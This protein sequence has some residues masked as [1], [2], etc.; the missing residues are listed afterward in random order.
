MQKSIASFIDHTILSPVAKKEDIISACQQADMWG[1]ASVCIHPY[2]VKLATKELQGS[3]CKVTTVVGF[4][5]GQNCFPTKVFET[6]KALEEGADEID[7]VLN[8]SAL[9]QGLDSF[10]LDELCSIKEASN[11]HIVK[12]IIET[13]YLADHEKKLAC[14]LILRSGADFVKTSTGFAKFGATVDDVLLLRKLVGSKIGVKASG[15][16]GTLEVAESM[17]RAGASRIGCSQTEAIV[18]GKP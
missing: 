14:E 8:I 12:V 7:V 1:C 6:K 16:I 2:F 3:L 5:L 13:A 17:L 15:G 4:P 9:K 10:V 11:F 18:F